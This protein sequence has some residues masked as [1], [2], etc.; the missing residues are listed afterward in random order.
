MADFVTLSCP[1]CGNKLKITEDLDRFA[2]IACGNEHMI[3]RGEG[4][5]SIKPITEG[6]KLIKTGVDKT[7]SELAIVRLKP[8]ISHIEHEIR[9][10]YNR[11]SNTKWH[12]VGEVI[13][14]FYAIGCSIY[15]LIALFM[16]EFTALLVPMVEAI[17]FTVAWVWVDQGRRNR[18]TGNQDKLD[19]LNA[20]L[21]QKQEELAK[22]EAIVAS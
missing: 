20:Q 13:L 10:I 19:H 1:S 16:G 22:H 15:F 5:I 18:K 12:V 21:L 2:C 4:T 17:V 14:G 11:R 3:I 9:G 6:L 7:A 8:E